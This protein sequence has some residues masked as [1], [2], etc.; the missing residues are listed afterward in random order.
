MKTPSMLKKNI[1]LVMCLLAMLLGAQAQNRPKKNK[2]AG[3]KK[4]QKVEIVVDTLQAD[5]L[6]ADSIQLPPQEPTMVFDRQEYNMGQ[7][8]NNTKPATY[9]FFYCNVGIDGLVIKRIESTCGCTVTQYTQDT[10][11][12]DQS[13]TIDVAVTPCKDTNPFKKGIYV[14]TNAGTFKLLLSGHFAQPNHSDE[15]YSAIPPHRLT[16]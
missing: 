9:T 7:I 6:A 10:L 11:Y 4:V 5:T 3:K 12:Y 15:D 2:T 1:L 14:Y 13:G 8:W 16:E